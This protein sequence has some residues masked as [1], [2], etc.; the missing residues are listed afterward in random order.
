MLDKIPNV[1]YFR[2][3]GC[4]AWVW[5]PDAIRKDKL[6]PKAEAMTFIG[7]IRGTKGWLFMCKDNSLFTG[8]NAKFN[9]LHF[10]RRENNKEPSPPGIKHGWNDEDSDEEDNNNYSSHQTPVKTTNKP[11]CHERIQEEIDKLQYFSPESDELSEHEL[12]GLEDIIPKTHMKAPS[13]PSTPVKKVP[14]PESTKLDKSK[15]KVLVQVPPAL[16]RSEHLKKPKLVQNSTYGRKQATDVLQ[17]T[18]KKFFE[19]IFE[20]NPFDEPDSPEKQASGSKTVQGNKAIRLLLS[21]AVKVLKELPASSKEVGDW[22]YKDVDKLR[23]TEPENY[24]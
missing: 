8:S 16:R 7:Y 2:T 9:E 4:P 11:T 1:E 10:P 15:K 18:D 19:E 21:K 5:L 20:D 6:Y 17:Q 14:P 12:E 22:T 13:L 24:K 3:F 23:L